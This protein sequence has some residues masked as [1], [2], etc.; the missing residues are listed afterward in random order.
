M[1]GPLREQELLAL[2]R[3]LRARAYRF[4]TVTPE[5][6]ELVRRR[7]RPDPPSLR[8]IFGWNHPFYPAQ[9]EA[10]AR[11]L[12]L[13]ADACR[14]AADGSWQ[15]AVRF[16]S[17]DDLLFVHSAFPTDERDSVFFGPDSHRFVRAIVPH[18]PR[19][20]RLVDVGCGTGIGGIV[21][22]R[23][24]GKGVP[25]VLAD[26]NPRALAMARVN[27]ALAEVSVEIVESD[28]LGG[29]DGPVNVVISN[30]PY[31]SD[32]ARRVYRDG[33]ARHGAA[34]S[35]RIARESLNRLERSSAGGKLL[36]YSGAAI[37]EGRDC[38]WQELEPELRRAHYT[39]EELDPDVFGNELRSSAYADVER[40]AA[41]FLHASV[42]A[43]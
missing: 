8:D 3:F 34:L 7:Q 21:A 35:A 5:T 22:A 20:G 42:D 28:V 17:F 36:L 39:Y 4:S 27:A 25:V 14:K 32:S 26:I 13:A 18:L 2:G 15:S 40:I 10:Q 31:V 6:H 12:L 16:S 30:P 1:N 29:V 38:L 33:G 19:D 43:R 9:L 23:Q 24:L 11:E 41:V 37:V